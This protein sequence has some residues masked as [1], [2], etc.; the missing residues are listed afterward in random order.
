MPTYEKVK[1]IER[2]MN[3]SGNDEDVKIEEHDEDD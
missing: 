3:E 1:D 2:G